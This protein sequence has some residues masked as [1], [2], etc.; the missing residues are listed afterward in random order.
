LF[1]P[2]MLLL[3]RSTITWSK[4]NAPSSAR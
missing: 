4:G 2:G 1:S 3:S